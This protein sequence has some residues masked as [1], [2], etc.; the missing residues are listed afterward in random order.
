MVYRPWRTGHG[1]CELCYKSNKTVGGGE[2]A[3]E[4]CDLLGQGGGRL[5]YC[6]D[7]FVGCM[8]NKLLRGESCQE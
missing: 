1:E 2:Q 6:K 7:H 8:Q 3:E 5:F 4:S